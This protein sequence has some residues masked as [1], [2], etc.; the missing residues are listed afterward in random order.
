MKN[1]IHSG[2]RAINRLGVMKVAANLDDRQ[3]VQE[4]RPALR[5]DEAKDFIPAGEKGFDQM[6]ADEPR[7]PGH[8]RFQF[9]ASIRM[10]GAILTE[11]KEPGQPRASLRHEAAMKPSSDFIRHSRFQKY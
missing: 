3:A 9:F 5:T 1:D 8:K 7:G 2:D 11:F 10:M 4:T 6:T